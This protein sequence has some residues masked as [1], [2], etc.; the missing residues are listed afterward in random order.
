MIQV[1]NIV[2]AFATVGFATAQ[3]LYLAKRNRDLDRAE[4]VD[5]QNEGVPIGTE[6]KKLLKRLQIGQSCSQPSFF[7]LTMAEPS[8]RYLL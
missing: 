2:F 4:Q 7:E 3:R 6:S 8:Y 1:A 5:T